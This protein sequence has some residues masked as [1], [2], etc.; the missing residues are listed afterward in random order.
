MV[1]ALTQTNLHQFQ[2]T[3]H[4]EFQQRQ[5]LLC[6]IEVNLGHGEVINED[7]QFLALRK[8]SKS[9]KSKLLPVKKKKLLRIGQEQHSRCFKIESNHFAAPSFSNRRPD[10]GQRCAQC[11]WRCCPATSVRMRSPLPQIV[12][13]LWFLG[14]SMVLWK[15]RL[16]CVQSNL[17]QTEQLSNN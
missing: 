12:V 15:S 14:T 1:H 10:Q 6:T 17:L 16:P 4:Q 3:F 5:W 13:S 9:G 11:V 7:T 8:T 2:A